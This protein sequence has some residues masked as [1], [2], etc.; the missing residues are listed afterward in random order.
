MENNR[1]DL[2]VILAGYKD[3]M[4]KFF[5]SNPIADDLSTITEANILTSPVSSGG[6]K[7][8]DTTRS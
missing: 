1:D 3:R 7:E 8:S 5:Q 4:K 2:V 6:L